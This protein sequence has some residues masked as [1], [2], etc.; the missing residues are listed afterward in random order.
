M[1][2]YSNLLRKEGQKNGQV[3]TTAVKIAIKNKKLG[4]E[5]IL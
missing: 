2:A 4:N 5:T 1:S 3:I